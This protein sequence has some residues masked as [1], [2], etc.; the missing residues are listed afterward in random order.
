[1][2]ALLQPIFLFALIEGK[3][4]RLPYDVPKASTTY[5]TRVFVGTSKIRSQA[6]VVLYS[7]IVCNNRSIVFKAKTEPRVLI[8][9]FL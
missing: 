9:L 1:M 4:L 7:P 8:K 2:C 5:T 6:E 3:Y